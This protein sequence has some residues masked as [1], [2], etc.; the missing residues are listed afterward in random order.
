[1]RINEMPQ[2][3]GRNCRKYMINCFGIT[4]LPYKELRGSQQEIKGETDD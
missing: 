3:S 2:F 1:M 4:G